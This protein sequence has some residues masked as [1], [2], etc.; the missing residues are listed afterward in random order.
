MFLFNN[1]VH[2][3][4]ATIYQR[5][6]LPNMSGLDEVETELN[7]LQRMDQNDVEGGMPQEQIAE[8]SG[9]F[10]VSLKFYSKSKEE[11]MKRAAHYCIFG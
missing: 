10:L 9:M 4:T 3:S 1:A 11:H 5:E 2:I 6:S 8:E 7:D